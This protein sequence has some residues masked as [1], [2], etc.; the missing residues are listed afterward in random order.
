MSWIENSVEEV[1]G[2]RTMTILPTPRWN[3]SYMEN[4]LDY[5][6]LSRIEVMVRLDDGKTSYFKDFWRVI[7][8]FS[9]TV[10]L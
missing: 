2:G 4:H 5:V 3:S 7:K 1:S 10:E 8:T 6:D 9:P